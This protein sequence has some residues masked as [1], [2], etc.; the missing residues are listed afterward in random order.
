MA[1][2]LDHSELL[3][4]P[5]AGHRFAREEGRLGY[6][7]I[8][9]DYPDSTIGTIATRAAHLAMIASGR[10]D[11]DPRVVAQSITDNVTSDFPCLDE[12]IE[13]A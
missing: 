6:D 4:G 2:S 12:T 7:L 9:L 10:F 1:D 11:V 8:A 13:E 5:D 3:D